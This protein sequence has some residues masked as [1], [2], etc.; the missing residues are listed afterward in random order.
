MKKILIG[1]MLLAGLMIE[2]SASAANWTGL[3]A[4]VNAGASINGTSYTVKPT[5]CFLNG[6]CGGVPTSNPLR[7]RSGEFESVDFVGGAQIGYDYEFNNGILLGV[8]A[9]FDGNTMDESSRL[10]RNLRAPLSGTW[11]SNVTDEMEWFGTVRGKFGYAVC[12]WLLFLT[13]GFAYGD[14]ESKTTSLFSLG[15][16]GYNGS[17]DKTRIGWTAGA[18]VAYAFDNQWSVG[19]EYLYVDLSDFSYTDNRNAL[20][21]ATASYKTSIDPRDN[22]V[23]FNLNYKFPCT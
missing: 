12:N 7:S 18:G 20:A 21:P 16:D 3:Y 6:T 17:S 1:S 13:G 14:V 4:G 5:G 10:V 22:I 15:G 11:T 8:L 23:R 2:G 9:D 19:L